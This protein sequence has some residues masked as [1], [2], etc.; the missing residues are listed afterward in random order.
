MNDKIKKSEFIC[1]CFKAVLSDGKPHRYREILNYTRQQAKE[2]KFDEE[3]EQNNMVQYI[4]TLIGKSDSKYERVR[5][6]GL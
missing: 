3:I 6:G 5:H 2:T 4:N 1:D